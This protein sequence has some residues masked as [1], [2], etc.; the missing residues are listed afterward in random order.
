M[1]GKGDVGD[2][3]RGISA[4]AQLGTALPTKF[5]RV[6]GIPLGSSRGASLQQRG[7]DRQPNQAG[8]SGWQRSSV[9]ASGFLEVR[10]RL[11]FEEGKGCRE[12]EGRRANDGR[13]HQRQCRVSHSHTTENRPWLAPGAE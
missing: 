12:V 8:V 4:H 11:A 9:S 5:G 2:F 1:E 10:V 6:G 3:R 7:G 13:K